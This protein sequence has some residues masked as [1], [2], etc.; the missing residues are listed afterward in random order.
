MDATLIS[1]GMALGGVI[2]TLAVTSYFSERRLKIQLRHDEKQRNYDLKKSVYLDLI[3]EYHIII[4]SLFKITEIEHRLITERCM[5]FY[6][7]CSQASLVSTRNSPNEFDN[8]RSKARYTVFEIFKAA[9][10]CMNTERKITS[11]NNQ[12]ETFSA[13]EGK[14]S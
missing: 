9:A 1:A 4:D 10:P 14:F 7:C 2:L 13:N 3:R 12:Y 5:I 8:L 6:A 11:N